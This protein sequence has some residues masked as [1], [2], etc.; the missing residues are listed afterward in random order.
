MDSITHFEEEDLKV[1]A[2]LQGEPAN[3]EEEKEIEDLKIEHP[4]ALQTT[5]ELLTHVPHQHKD[6]AN[7]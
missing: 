6:T 5:Q 3:E 2:Y 7:T 1:S 4:D